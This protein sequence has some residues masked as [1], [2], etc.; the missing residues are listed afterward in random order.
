ML[1]VAAFLINSVFNF[2]LGLLIARFLGPAGFGQYAIAAALA[3]VVNTL[4]LDWIRLAAT[5]FYSEK[6]RADDPSIRGTLDAIFALSSIGLTL[7]SGALILLG[8]DFNL[9]LALALLTP[10]M[11]VCNGL[12][13][14]HAA[15]L[16]ARFDQKGFALMVIVKNVLSLAFMVGG[17]L[18][19]QS[20]IAVAAG[21]ILSV[22]ATLAIAWRRLRDPGVEIL[23]PDWMRAQG[24][25]AYGFPVVLAILIYYLIPLWNR[26]AIAG[27]LGFAASGQFS[28]AYDIAVRTVQTVGSALDIILFQLALK[29]EDERG[30]EE[31]KAQLSANMGIVLLA[32]M[33]VVAGYWLILPSFEA[34]LVP[35]PFRGAFAEVTTILLPGLACYALI[36]YA[37]TPVLQLGRR[38]WPVV[39]CA[40]LALV[41]NALL[42]LPLGQ[43]A[44]ITDYARAQS[45]AYGVALF[46]AVL[47]A[48]G[49]MR[50]LPKARDGAA[51]V[52][53]VLAMAAA[54][55]PI[56]AMGPGWIPLALSIIAGGAAFAVVALAFDAGGLRVR[57]RSALKRAAQPSVA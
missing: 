41:V 9:A 33:A 50:V 34:A 19:L 23:R 44:R 18:W 2:A 17:A 30:I 11:G 37:A 54:I 56:R 15:L 43:E 47:L 48:A 46:A 14:Y 42:V 22:I 1:V 6:S 36:Q 45:F 29:T 39:L 40:L 13:D 20:P 52:V 3:V 26:A 4:F 49:H 51:A 5:R 57:L 7:A 32:V 25:L 53:A 8:H 10:A 21:F 27:E 35:Q 28:L 16:R 38:T 55:W 24:F 12:F 31:A